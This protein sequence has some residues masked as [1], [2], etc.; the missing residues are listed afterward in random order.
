MVQRWKSLLHSSSFFPWEYVD[1]LSI[2][3]NV[4]G[5]LQCGGSVLGAGNPMLRASTRYGSHLHRAQSLEQEVGVY[6]AVMQE[7]IHSPV[8]AWFRGP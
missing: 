8:E 1:F 6:L 5:G 7:N 4:Y 3:L 2:Q